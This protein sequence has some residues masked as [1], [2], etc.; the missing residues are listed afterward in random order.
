MRI[1]AVKASTVRKDPATPPSWLSESVIAN[2]MSGYEQYAARRSSWQAKFPQVAVEIETDEGLSGL[3]LTIGGDATIAI[4]EQH[5]SALLVGQDPGDTE[6]LWDQMYRASLPYGR[7]GL[8]IMAISGVDQALWDLNGKHYG[9]PVYRLLGGA[10]RPDLP[11]YQTTNDPKDW[12]ECDGLGI[13]L[14]LPFGPADGREG[15]RENVELVRRCRDVL[16]PGRDIMIDCYMALDVEYTRRFIGMIEQLSVRW[17]EEPLLPDDYTGYERLAAIDSPV[18][19]ATGEHEYTRWGFQR[20]I[21]TGGVAILQPD[22]AWVGGIT[23]AVKI[24]HLASAFNL[25]VVPHAGGL[26]AG[27]LHLM[28]SQSNTPFAEWVRTWDRAAGRPRGPVE[29]VPDPADG[30]IRP[31]ETAGLGLRLTDE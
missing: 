16:G 19:I 5:F 4:I 10:C 3:G 24:C 1:T 9:V 15:L 13:K 8:P 21:D 31:A 14:A 25:N 22:V 12:E 2:P 17:V 27:A 29:G 18:L 30:R 6:R 20:L 7:M 28:L 11:V 26:Q 23:E